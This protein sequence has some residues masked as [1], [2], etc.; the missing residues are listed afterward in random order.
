MGSP[1]PCLLPS[2]LWA[3]FEDLF[4]I[5]PPP[6]EESVV[7][8]SIVDFFPPI[9]SLVNPYLPPIF[10]RFFRSPGPVVRPSGYRCSLS[11]RF[12]F[13]LFPRLFPVPG[14]GFFGRAPSPPP[15]RP[16]A[17]SPGAFLPASSS[18]PFGVLVGEGRRRF[19]SVFGANYSRQPTSSTLCPRFPPPKPVFCTFFFRWLGTSQC[20]PSAPFLSSSSFFLQ[21]IDFPF[22]RPVSFEG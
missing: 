17:L 11:V 14:R 19:F 4:K 2:L 3:T 15:H 16:P 1:P 12:H 22:F 8:V 20:P 21:R 9:F 5:L 10:P 18:S 7:F 6:C 13:P